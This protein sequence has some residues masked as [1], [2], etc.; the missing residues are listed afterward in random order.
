MGQKS[1]ANVRKPDLKRTVLARVRRELA[2]R[3]CIISLHKCNLGSFN[4]FPVVTPLIPIPHSHSPF[5]FPFPVLIPR[6]HSPFPFPDSLFPILKIT[7]CSLIV[8]LMR[9]ERCSRDTDWTVSKY[10]VNLLAENLPKRTKINIFPKFYNLSTG[11][12]QL[13]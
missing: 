12:I 13:L 8:I 1:I 2:Y 5:P 10:S 6:S 7:Y 4:I 11:F 9:Y 3:G